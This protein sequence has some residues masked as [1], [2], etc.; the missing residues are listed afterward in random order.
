MIFFFFFFFKKK[1]WNFFKLFFFFFFSREDWIAK[2]GREEE[3][4]TYRLNVCAPILYRGPEDDP[5]PENVAAHQQETDKPEK[6]FNLGVVSTDL[7]YSG[8]FFFDPWII[9]D[10]LFLTK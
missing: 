7:V 8:F 6:H 1:S 3:K 5:I 2:D 9:Y 10:Y 4:Y